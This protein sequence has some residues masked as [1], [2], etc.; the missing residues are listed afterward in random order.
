MTYLCK[1]TTMTSIPPSLQTGN[2]GSDVYASTGDPRLDLSVN[3]VRSVDPEKLVKGIKAVLELN[4]EQA[5]EDAF[6]QA[7]HA[8][9]V[10]GGKGER[11]VFKT[12]FQ[13]LAEQKPEL[14]KVCLK[15]IP[16]YGCWNDVFELAAKT[17]QADMKE[18]IIDLVI[19]QFNSDLSAP[20]GTSISLLAKWAPR[21]HKHPELMKCLAYRMFSSIKH[22]S[23][24]MK[25]YRQMVSKL[26]KRLNTV[27]T[28]M[29]ADRWD[30]I[31]PETV[32]GRAGKLYN[33]AFLNLP[34]THHPTEESAAPSSISNVFRHP[35]NP[36]RVACR[37]HF[38][39]HYEAAAKGEAKVHG[40][41]TLFPHEI[42]K[43]AV[44]SSKELTEDEKNHL[45]GVWRGFVSKLSTAGGLG[46]SIFMSDFSGSMMHSSAGDT[47][48]WVSM[49]LGILGSEVCTEEFKNKL[50]TFDS[51]PVWHTFPEGA[52]LFAK[53]RSI[54][55]SRVGQG[56]STDFQKA[57]DLVLQTL[58]ERRVRPGQEPEN[59]IVLT[60][61]N[62]DAACGS[63]ET[64][65]YT[66]N[67][68]R[69]VVKTESWQTHVGMIQEAFK[70]AGEDM[71]GPGQGFV[72]PRIVIWNLAASTQ[73]DYHTTADV[74]GVAML[75]GWSPAQFEVLQKEGPRQLTAYEILRMELDDA[76]YERVRK[77]VREAL[78]AIHTTNEV[79]IEHLS[80][81]V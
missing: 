55:S 63:A 39:A 77:A 74:P 70:R 18:A 54:M 61:M 66:H 3:C 35:D 73:T 19:T 7:F 53:I 62:W 59:L 57:M 17:S 26:N 44:L 30:E 31:K 50:M 45:R 33:R 71:W 47:P 15:F 38:T 6:V 49:A 41:D 43:R 58:K 64:S 36:K 29:C 16:H 23:S 69:H 24:K 28:L 67:S 1:S 9:N 48:Y 78:A 34:S 75:S 11:D 72:P 12:L 81:S 13:T 42:A 56:L 20:E 32:P 76:K 40:A 37:E 27:E 68:Y 52:D 10:R 65:K 25:Q 14:V 5:I 46:R 8:R 22:H 21:E 4:T 80:A 60:D 2:K 51:D 79:I